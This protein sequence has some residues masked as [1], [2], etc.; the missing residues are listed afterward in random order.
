MQKEERGEG[1]RAS[2][3]GKKK[4]RRRKREERLGGG[5]GREREEE[6]TDRDRDKR[7]RDRQTDRQAGRRT[8]RL[9]DRQKETTETKRQKTESWEVREGEEERGSK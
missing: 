7:D 3:R 2:G 9:T 1:G 5:G 6:E 8:Y 4:K